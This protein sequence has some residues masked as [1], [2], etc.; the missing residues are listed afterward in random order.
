MLYPMYG[1]SDILQGFCRQCAVFGGNYVIAED[2]STEA[3]L[4]L[5]GVKK[6]CTSFGELSGL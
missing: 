5:E 1:T 3:I 2:I 6:L 4:A